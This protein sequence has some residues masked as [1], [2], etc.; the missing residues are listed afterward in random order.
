MGCFVTY[1][2]VQYVQ[3]SHS[4]TSLD[5][6]LRMIDC[7]KLPKLLSMNSSIIK[8]N[9]DGMLSMNQW[10]FISEEKGNSSLGP[11]SCKN[12]P[13]RDSMS[14]Q[15]VCESGVGWLN[16]F[17][18]SK[19]TQ[20]EEKLLCDFTIVIASEIRGGRYLPHGGV[21]SPSR[22]PWTHRDMVQVAANPTRSNREYK[23]SV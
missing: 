1:A 4:P 21:C 22:W 17:Q 7:H 13:P 19:F 9:K 23:T 8:R 18:T 5:V 15:G 14:N 20:R 16:T 6:H 11:L 3:I 10:Q 2:A 12:Y